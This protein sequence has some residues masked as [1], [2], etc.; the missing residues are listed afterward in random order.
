MRRRH[1]VRPDVIVLPAWN[2]RQRKVPR[3]KFRAWSRAEDAQW[4]AKRLLLDERVRQMA[5]LQA[6]IEALKAGAPKACAGEPSAALRRTP[7]FVGIDVQAD[8]R[9]GVTL[10]RGEK[11]NAVYALA[12]LG[13]VLT[14][15][16]PQAL[17]E[18]LEM[19]QEE[20]GASGS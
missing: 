11:K 19:A 1:V 8:G 9:F 14:R 16:L 12:G 3:Y 17:E 18:A 20:A 5:E 10:W 4:E 2:G 6:A 13:E 15:K 7:I